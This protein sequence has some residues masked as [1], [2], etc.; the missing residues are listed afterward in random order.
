MHVIPNPPCHLKDSLSLLLWHKQR[1][2][3]SQV[4]IRSRFSQSLCFS[5]LLYPMSLIVQIC[6]EG[7]IPGENPTP[8]EQSWVFR[9]PYLG[10]RKSA[11]PQLPFA[12]LLLGPSWFFPRQR[13]TFNLLPTRP[14]PL[15]ILILEK[16]RW[17]RNLPEAPL[18]ETA[19]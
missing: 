16:A 1:G 9:Q 5:V 14:Y 12:I 19:I 18:L 3:I 13:K 7:F 6:S 17:G 11:V 2:K 4:S 15:R 10:I 8:R